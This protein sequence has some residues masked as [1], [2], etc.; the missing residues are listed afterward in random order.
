MADYPVDVIQHERA[1]RL[2]VGDL[3]EVELESGPVLR[4]RSVIVATGARWRDMNV[5]GERE[6]R[7]RGVTHLP[8]LRRTAVRGQARG[9]HRRRQLRRRGRHRSAGWSRT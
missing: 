2:V 3:V 9:R 6:Y 8:A 7:T 4:A 5:P 1:K